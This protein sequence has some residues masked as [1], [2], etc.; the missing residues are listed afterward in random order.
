MPSPEIAIAASARDWPDRL[1]RFLLDHGGGVVTARV[2]GSDQALQESFQAL[3]IDDVCSFLTPRLVAKLREQGRE[4]LGVFSPDDGPD[5]KRRLL[6]CGIS[7]VVEMDASPEEVLELVVR[8]LAHRTPSPKAD[9]ERRRYGNTIVVSGS[10]SGVG[11]T[12]VSIVLAAHLASAASVVLADLDQALPGVAQRLDLPLYPNLHTAV[13]FA[14]HDPER[15]AEAIHVTD[16]VSVV[17]GLARSDPSRLIPSQELVG[18]VDDLA[19]SHEFVVVDIGAGAVDLDSSATVVVGEASPVGLSRLI[20]RLERF[21][22][23]DGAL[24]LVNRVRGG[25]RARDEIRYELE[26]ALPD[27]RVAFAPEDPKVPSMAWD[28]RIPRRGG[29]SKSI[30]TLARAVLAEAT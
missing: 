23:G 3:L 25:R 29:F 15:L 9:G 4:V 18:M 2:M 6:E 27:V 22:A 20:D 7:D 5:A 26:R 11:C 10:A 24:A 16:G 8:T 19:T 13:D 21:R 17:G 14:F 30:K 1:H 12:E 28:G